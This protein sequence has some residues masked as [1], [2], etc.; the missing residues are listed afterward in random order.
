DAVIQTWVESP[1]HLLPESTPGTLTNIALQYLRPR[2]SV[3]LERPKP[4]FLRGRVADQNG[5]PVPKAVVS[6]QATDVEG[7][8][9]PRDHVVEGMVPDR[10]ASALVA[11]RIH[12]EAPPARGCPVKARIGPI[13]YKSGAD[14]RTIP[15]SGKEGAESSYLI[16]PDQSVVINFPAF[17]VSQNS[18]FVA[19]I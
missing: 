13:R 11:V 19:T 10:A 14:V 12:S 2:S 17:P 15:V 1:S 9:A 6:I 5:R 8:A 4:G 18:P 3:T 16:Q 7:I